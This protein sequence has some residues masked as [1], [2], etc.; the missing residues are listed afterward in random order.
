[1][2][3]KPKWDHD[4]LKI[5]T[6]LNLQKNQKFNKPSRVPQKIL[7]HTRQRFL[8]VMMDSLHQDLLQHHMEKINLA[9]NSM[10]IQVENRIQLHIVIANHHQ[11]FTEW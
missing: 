5:I 8:A 3:P 11:E 1:M 9:H 7:F 6:S 2:S 4:T 10:R